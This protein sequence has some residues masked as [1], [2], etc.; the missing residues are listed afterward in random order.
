M[1]IGAA[2]A[3]AIPLV[4]QL[5]CINSNLKSLCNESRQIK[6]G[7]GKHSDVDPD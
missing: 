3:I 7:L 1:V 6:E 4:Y 2:I 5:Y